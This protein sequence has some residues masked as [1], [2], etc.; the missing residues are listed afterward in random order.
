MTVL[1]THTYPEKRKPRRKGPPPSPQELEKR[2][3]CTECS[4]K[5]M[6]KYMTRHIYREHKLEKACCD[7]CGKSYRNKYQ[8]QVHW[9]LAHKVEE[10]VQCKIC[11]KS[12]QNEMKLRKHLKNHDIQNLNL[13]TQNFVSNEKLLEAKVR[14]DVA[15]GVIC[16]LCDLNF[17]N[18]SNLKRHTLECL[19]MYDKESQ[20]NTRIKHKDQEDVDGTISPRLD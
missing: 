20:K 7:E 18:I 17:P 12:C 3:E 2:V 13:G 10:N 5:I 19:K 8:M 11:S 15:E 9:N 1:K 6:S 16:N 14:D 4:A